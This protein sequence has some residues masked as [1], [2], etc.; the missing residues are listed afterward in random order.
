MTT[1]EARLVVDSLVSDHLLHFIH[2]F[3]TLDTDIVD[4]FSR[5]NLS[6][7]AHRTALIVQKD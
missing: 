4:H 3:T 2:S 7:D 6:A 1:A 5:C